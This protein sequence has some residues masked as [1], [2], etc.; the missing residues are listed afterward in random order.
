VAGAAS[1]AGALRLR[2]RL[3][4]RTV[5]LVLSGGNVTVEQPRRALAG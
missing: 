1:P 5:G 4:G 3:A 2:E